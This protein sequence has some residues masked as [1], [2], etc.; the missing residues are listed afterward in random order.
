MQTLN[1]IDTPRAQF[2]AAQVFSGR[3]GQENYRKL[4]LAEQLQTSLDLTGLLNIFS[5]EVSKIVDFSGLYF[6]KGNLTAQVRGSETA[7]NERLFELRI[8]QQ[9]IGTL[10]YAINSPISLAHYKILTELHQLLI[11]PINNAIAYQKAMSLAMHDELT[12][13]GNRRYFDQQIKRAMHHANRQVSQLGLMVCD[14]DKFKA[15]ND[16]HGHCIGDQVLIEFSK[17]LKASVR[18]SDSVFRFG[19]DE[20]AIIIEDASEKSLFIIEK[21]LSRALNH[22]PLLAKYQVACSSGFTFMIRD[23]NEQSFFE[24]ADTILYRKKHHISQVLSIV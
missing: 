16:N 19:G 7:K 6:K 11:H 1:V 20:F 18:D 14:L 23:D 12:S 8:N 17:A 22:N 2:R 21:R 10:T 5:M 9:Y 3:D 15:I 4:V 24:R 13:L